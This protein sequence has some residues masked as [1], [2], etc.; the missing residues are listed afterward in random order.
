M[1]IE[2]PSTERALGPWSSV[3]IRHGFS[4]FYVPWTCTLGLRE[5][6]WLPE[7]PHLIRS[8]FIKLNLNPQTSLH[9]TSQFPSP[10]LSVLNSFHY[11]Y[12][13]IFL[14]ICLFHWSREPS[15]W[16]NGMWTLFRVWKPW[17]LTQTLASSLHWESPWGLVKTQTSR[18]AL[19]FWL[20]RSEQPLVVAD[21]ANLRTTLL[22]AI[23]LEL[24]MGYSKGP[25]HVL[26]YVGW[27]E[28]QS[29][30]LGDPGDCL[31]APSDSPGCWV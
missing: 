6:R 10:L 1:G 30:I 3:W 14:L 29:V 22:T 18:L 4:N 13:W 5:A 12:Y 15:S 25:V 26:G 27:W 7:T 19:G 21:V 28:R 8:F 2:S 9:A 11:N 23:D 16:G 20:G 17:M 31:T 24:L